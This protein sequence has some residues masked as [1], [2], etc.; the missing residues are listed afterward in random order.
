MTIGT[1]DASEFGDGDR[2]IVG[3][4][5]RRIG[6]GRVDHAMIGRDEYD[7]GVSEVFGQRHGLLAAAVDAA[8]DAAGTAAVATAG[9][10]DALAPCVELAAQTAA[11][12]AT[13]ALVSVLAIRSIRLAA[14][15]AGTAGTAARRAAARRAAAAGR[16]RRGRGGGEVGKKS[17]RTMTLMALDEDA[18]E[19]DYDDRGEGA[20][21]ENKIDEID[22]VESVSRLMTPRGKLDTT[23]DHKKELQSEQKKEREGINR[24]NPSR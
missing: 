16:R 8:V 6:V 23:H 21:V 10:V 2:L 7:I 24:G 15:T 22:T 20:P 4:R 14:G 12:A 18:D 17:E 1:S 19:G 13:A 9:I 11:M 5:G 3:E